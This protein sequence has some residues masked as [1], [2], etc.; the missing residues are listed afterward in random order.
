MAVGCTDGENWERNDGKVD[1]RKN[2]KRN[3]GKEL[4]VQKG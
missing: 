4:N 2:M 3:E 1:R